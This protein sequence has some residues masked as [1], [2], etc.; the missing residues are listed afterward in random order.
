MVSYR[1][2]FLSQVNCDFNKLTVAR[3]SPKSVFSILPFTI[4]ACSASVSMSRW[5]VMIGV[6]IVRDALMISLIRGTPRVMCN[7]VSRRQTNHQK[8]LPHTR[9]LCNLILKARIQEMCTYSYKNYHMALVRHPCSHTY[10]CSLINTTDQCSK[11]NVLIKSPH[12]QNMV[13]RLY[14]QT[15]CVAI[16]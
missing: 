8:W 15:L 7:Q 16:V 13:S 10:T 11:T 6:L 12:M 14:Q 1:S 5:A 2:Q 3:T 4:L 9:L